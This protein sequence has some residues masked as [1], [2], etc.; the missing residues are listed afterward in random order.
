MADEPEIH[1]AASAVSES[2]CGNTYSGEGRW[3]LVFFVHD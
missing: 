1:D 3:P 2:L